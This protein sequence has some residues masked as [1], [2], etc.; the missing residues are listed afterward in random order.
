MCHP[1]LEQRPVTEA[2]Q[3]IVQRL[4]AQMLFQRHALGHVANREHDAVHVWISEQVRGDGFRA[5]PFAIGANHPAADVTGRRT[6]H[7]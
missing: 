4:M 3:R 1:I 2:S 6:P 7:Q 5:H